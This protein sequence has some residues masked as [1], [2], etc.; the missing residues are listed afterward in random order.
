[1]T[2]IG[3]G[4][5]IGKVER[6][7]G[8]MQ[9]HIATDAA[10]TGTQGVVDRDRISPRLAVV[11]AQIAPAGIVV[12]RAADARALRRDRIAMAV[13]PR[14]AILPAHASLD[15]GKA[16]DLPAFEAR[17]RPDDLVRADADPLL[18]DR[19]GGRALAGKPGE[20]AVENKET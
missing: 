17:L 2:V 14:H 10:K 7:T 20:L 5:Q 11:I 8:A 9:E 1:M 15:Q 19:E 6:H 13:Q 12:E 3:G 16:L 18:D 4:R